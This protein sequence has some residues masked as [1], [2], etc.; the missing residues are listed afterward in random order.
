MSRRTKVE[1]RIQKQKEKLLNL[2]EKRAVLIKNEEEENQKLPQGK[3]KE[4]K[5]DRKK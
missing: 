1:K 4:T 2:Q 5:K 3:L